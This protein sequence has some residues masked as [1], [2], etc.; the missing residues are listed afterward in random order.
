[1]TPMIAAMTRLADVLE[2]ENAALRSMDMATATGLLAEKTQTL[3]DI[4]A[5]QTM[6]LAVSPVTPALPTGVPM[7]LPNRLRILTTE[8]QRLLEIALLAQGRVVSLI[9]RVACVQHNHSTAGYG[10]G[11]CP[12]P[13]RPPALAVSARA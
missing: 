5:I 12:K 13:S 11:G 6:E 3:A 4:T 7:G 2:R 9:A 8:N 10:S 1:M